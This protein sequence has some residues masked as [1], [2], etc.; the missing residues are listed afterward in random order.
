MNHRVFGYA[1]LFVILGSPLLLTGGNEALFTVLLGLTLLLSFLFL[2]GQPIDGALKV[3]LRLFLAFI[4]C[5]LLTLIPMPVSWIRWLSPGLHKVLLHFP[6][7]TTHTLS[8]DAILTMKTLAIYVAAAGVF[9][10]AYHLWEDPLEKVPFTVQLFFWTGAFWVAA[11]LWLHYATPGRIPF[12]PWQPEPWFFGLFTNENI[13]GSY[14][15]FLIPLSIG[16]GLYR[17]RTW[18]RAPGIAPVIFL[19]AGFVG[20]A[21]VVSRSA[22]AVLAL[23]AVLLCQFLPKRAI[24]A[25]LALALATAAILYWGPVIDAAAYESM[26]ERLRIARIALRSTLSMPLFGSGLG[27]S[28]LVLPIVQGPMGNRIVD[29]A[30]NEAVELLLTGGL[31]ALLLAGSLV[32]LGSWIL[33][34]F[35]WKST[36]RGGLA[37]A[38]GVVAIHSLADFPLQNYSVLATTV[39]CAGALACTRERGSALCPSR[40]R[41]IA[42]GVIGVAGLV[43]GISLVGLWRIERGAISVWIPAKSYPRARGDLERLDRLAAH[44]RLDALAWGERALTLEGLNMFGEARSS[45][46]RAIVLQPWNPRLLEIRA[47]LAY[48]AGDESALA[49]DL[50]RIFALAGLPVLNKYPLEPAVQER[51]LQAGADAAFGYYGAKAASQTR[52]AYHH[53]RSLQS[54][55]RAEFIRRAARRFPTNEMIQGDATAEML[56]AGRPEDAL[57]YAKAALL[58]SRRAHNATLVA[59]ALAAQHRDDEAMVAFELALD[60]AEDDRDAAKVVSWLP[61]ALSRRSPEEILAFARRAFRIFPSATVGLVMARQERRR[62]DLREASAWYERAVELA[63]GDSVLYREFIDMLKAAGDTG[64]LDLH[65]QQFAKRFP[66]EPQPGTPDQGTGYKQ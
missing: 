51:I 65:L 32:V 30:H 26:M 40:E 34:F 7:I 4:G 17:I 12:L 21:L 5:Q 50:T 57:A 36:L 25:P 53:L 49:E 48:Y 59:R 61:V 23:G 27:T 46:D 41:G 60:L 47:R 55:E 10:V 52:L 6:E 19:A 62:G 20:W 28:E 42:L 29:K 54:R 18:N 1:L 45:V 15:A 66:Q 24:A 38:L 58:L 14:C 63:P 39:F 64:R 44:H 16:L 9:L 56:E 35:R 2:L 22:G 13:F 11:S 43:A 33:R 31:T 37:A 3:P 8:W